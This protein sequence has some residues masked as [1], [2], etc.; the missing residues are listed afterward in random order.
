MTCQEENIKGVNLLKETCKRSRGS[1]KATQQWSKKHKPEP[2]NQHGEAPISNQ[3]EGEKLQQLPEGSQS[4]HN[5]STSPTPQ[6][7]GI[8]QTN[9]ITINQNS[10]EDPTASHPMDS[11]Q[12][13]EPARSNIDIMKT[14]IEIM[15]AELSKA[16][17]GNIEGELFS[18]QASFPT[19]AG[20]PEED[21]VYAYFGSRYN[22]SPS[23]DEAT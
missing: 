17:V 6:T 16:T 13:T 12:R 1:F 22:V 2:P 19:Y 9:N 4:R 14:M 23:G 21:P 15:E 10:S 20:F 8:G 7:R 18:L 11:R 5:D 3:Q